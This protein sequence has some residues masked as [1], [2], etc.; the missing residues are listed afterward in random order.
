MSVR[1]NIVIKPISDVIEKFIIKNLNKRAPMIYS[2]ISE[3]ELDGIYR[4]TVNNFPDSKDELSTD[5]IKSMRN[6]WTR[7]HMIKYNKNLYKNSKKIIS[8]YNK[9]KLNVLQICKSYDVSPLNLLREI[10]DRKYHK[11]L[12]KLIINPEIL[13]EYDLIQLNLAIENDVYALIDQSQIQKDSEKFELDIKKILDQNNIKYKTQEEL[14]VEQIKNHGMPINTPDFLI[15]SDLY[16]NG[17]KINWIDAK[18]FYGSN[19]PFVSDKIKKQTEKYVKTWGPG[20]IIFSLGFN[21]KLH[22]NNII[23]IDYRELEKN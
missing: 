15:K 20:S 11:K 13:S 4:K 7:N 10:F 8:D 18:N 12:S 2:K 17:R 6:S 16:I 22:Y 9:K 5:L 23:L 14:V 19:V 1:F 3:K 21:E